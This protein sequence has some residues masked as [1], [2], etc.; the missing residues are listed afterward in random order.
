M[1]F[2]LLSCAEVAQVVVFHQ[3]EHIAGGGCRKEPPVLTPVVVVVED[4][5]YGG[6]FEKVG[7]HGGVDWGWDDYKGKLMK[8]LINYTIFT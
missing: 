7:W 1:F 5:G 8:I 4:R 3:L 2:L 6:L